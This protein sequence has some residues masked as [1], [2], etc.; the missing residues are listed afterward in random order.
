MK[1]SSLY[2]ASALPPHPSPGD[3][4]R[5]AIAVSPVKNFAENNAIIHGTT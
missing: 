2:G 1:E 3:L 4:H 5:A